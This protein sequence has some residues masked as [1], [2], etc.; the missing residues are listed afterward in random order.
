MDPNLLYMMGAALS[1]GIDPNTP[2]G[3]NMSNIGQGMASAMQYMQKLEQEKAQQERLNR[4]LEI[5]EKYYQIQNRLQRRG[6][7]QDRRE[8]EA[9]QLEKQQKE[10][11]ETSTRAARSAALR[12]RYP[13]TFGS[14]SEEAISPYVTDDVLSRQ[15]LSPEKPKTD[16]TGRFINVEGVWQYADPDDPESI[17][18]VVGSVAGNPPKPDKGDKEEPALT[19][20]QA[21]TLVNAETTRLQ[22]E[23]GRSKPTEGGALSEGPDTRHEEIRARAAREVA[24]RVMRERNLTPEQLP[25]ILRNSLRSGAFDAGTETDDLDSAI[26]NF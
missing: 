18:R 10:A 14:M 16:R 21:E 22:K 15:Y 13:D 11:L 3:I 9:E 17:A 2:G 20:A 7:R 25:P 1:S 5:R 4:E 19:D 26:L 6:L 12:E 24:E 8:F 23:L